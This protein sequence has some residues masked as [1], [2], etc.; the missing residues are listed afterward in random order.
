MQKEFS[1]SRIRQLLSFGRPTAFFCFTIDRT[2]LFLLNNTCKSSA[3]PHTIR[4]VYIGVIL[5][6]KTKVLPRLSFGAQTL[7]MLGALVS[8]VALPQL[9]HLVGALSGLGTALGATFLPMHMPIIL[10]GFLA[11]P[12]AGAVAGALAPVV[13][14]A[15]SGMP[16]LAMLPLMI[17]EL[18]AYGFFAGLL[19]NTKLPS[20]FKLLFVQLLGRAVRA[21]VTLVVVLTVSGTSITLSSVYTSILSGLPGILLQWATLPLLLFFVQSKL[22]GR[23]EN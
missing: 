19:R 18:A 13:S 6:E 21:A 4:Q 12:Y 7:A 22:N 5:L 10:V 23:K 16:T 9:F 14:F 8:A 17:G 20:F 3:E 15:L 1:L 2:V 11:G